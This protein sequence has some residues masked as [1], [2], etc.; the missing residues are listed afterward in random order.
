MLTAALQLQ[1]FSIVMERDFARVVPTSE[2][3]SQVA[4][5]QRDG[6]RSGVATRI[7]NLQHEDAAQVL[8]AIRALVPASS[9]MTVHPSTNSL[10]VSD[11]PEN[12]RRIFEIIAS[13]DQADRRFMRVVTLSHGFSADIA[14]AVDQLM[15]FS[16]RV[17]AARLPEHQVVTLFPDSRLNRLIIQ[18]ADESR[19]LQAEKLAKE[20]DSPLSVPGNV[21]VIYLK[22]AEAVV[23]AKM[24]EGIFTS[25]IFGGVNSSQGDKIGR[26]SLG[27][28]GASV[29]SGGTISP[30]SGQA[31]GAQSGGTA[32]ANSSQVS[33]SLPAAESGSLGGG[34]S[35]RGPAASGVVIQADATLNALVVVAPESIFKEIRQVVDKLDIRR[36]QVFI[37]SIIVEVS[38]EKAAEFG[39]QF[40]YLDGLSSGSNARG[41]LVGGTNFNARGSGRNLLDLTANPLSVSQGLNIGVISGTVTFGGLT[42]A[43]LGLIAQALESKGNGN[44]IATPNL[45]TLDNEEAKIVIG[46]NVPFL[47]GSF[48]T[49]GNQSSNPFQ[50]IER[51]D[52]GTTLKVRPTV[53]E[54]G[55][56]RLQIFQEV[57]SVNARLSEGI[58]TNKRAIEST[59]LVDDQQIVV[60][61]GLIQDEQANDTSQIPLLGDVP[62]FGSLFR[63]ESRQRK[64]TNLFVFLRPVIIRSASESNT[65]SLGRYETIR[66][67]QQSQST[68]ESGF[69]IPRLGRPE[70]PL[71]PGELSGGLG[72]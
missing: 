63:S 40:Q 43:N 57:S 28:S 72:R 45:L 54:G 14:V 22:N 50:T 53:M 18:G 39:V 13:L 65:L 36:A 16:R 20:L 58:V 12:L 25:A 6:T 42:L 32:I 10:V 44:I 34:A 62:I 3:K 52:V 64:K 8:S 11:T 4:E 23:L 35:A 41:E 69:V 27:A 37:E 49:A 15:N 24:L 71:D 66:S 9:P 1:G 2:A 46:Q 61:G 19:V 26:S 5:L 17:R 30:L 21:H 51:R 38:A 31:R 67:A 70:L 47:T 60:L 68:Q 29:S 33:G 56:V 59:V 48:T 7:F 55:T